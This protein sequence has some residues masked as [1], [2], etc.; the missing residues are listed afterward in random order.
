MKGWYALYTEHRKMFVRHVQMLA[1][2]PPLVGDVIVMGD[3]W[4]YQVVR[5]QHVYSDTNPAELRVFCLVLE[6]PE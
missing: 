5:R 3:G 6:S 4:E 2:S 1:D